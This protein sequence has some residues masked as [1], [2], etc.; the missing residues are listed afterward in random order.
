MTKEFVVNSFFGNNPF[1]E[2]SIISAALLALLRR[3]G[4]LRALYCYSVI[5]GVLVWSNSS[6]S[7]SNSANFLLLVIIF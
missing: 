5:H 2:K 3:K 7:S 6:Y 1:V 4:W